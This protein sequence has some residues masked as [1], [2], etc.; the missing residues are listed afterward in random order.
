MSQIIGILS[1]TIESHC[2]LGDMHRHMNHEEG[3]KTFYDTGVVFR[4]WEGE[5]RNPFYAELCRF[6]CLRRA[7][8]KRQ[9]P[10]TVKIWQKM[11]CEIEGLSYPMY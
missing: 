4:R 2:T 10:P 9:N 7:F 1:Q 11:G 3:P 5:F 8:H 6:L